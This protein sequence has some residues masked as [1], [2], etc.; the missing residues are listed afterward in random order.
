MTIK[1]YLDSNIFIEAYESE[2]SER[3]EAA[4]SVLKMVD[5]GG[6]EAVISE[7][8]IAEILVKP[9]AEGDY[10][11]ANIYSELFAPQIG[12][13][14]CPVDRNSL[15]E[16]ARQRAVH[17]AT[18]LPDAIHIATARL[19]GCKAFLTSEARLRVPSDLVR[20]NLSASTTSELLSLM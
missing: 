8:V 16:A 9:L 7:L 1:I 2:S 5:E 17:A 3:S 11:L 18:K 10:T 13:T 19:Q 15:L 12:Y 4:R 20:V 14:T 6:V